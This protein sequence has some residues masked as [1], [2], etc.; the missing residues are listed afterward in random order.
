VGVENCRYT[1]FLKRLIETPWSQSPK[2]QGQQVKLFLSVLQAVDL[3]PGVAFGALKV[4]LLDQCHNL[5]VVVARVLGYSLLDLIP[6][7]TQKELVQLVELGGDALEQRKNAGVQVHLQTLAVCLSIALK[8]MDS[9]RDGINVLP[10]FSPIVLKSM[11]ACLEPQEPVSGGCLL[12][13][14]VSAEGQDENSALNGHALWQGTARQLFLLGSAYPLQAMLEQTAQDFEKFKCCFDDHIADDIIDSWASNCTTDALVFVGML[15]K[16]TLKTDDAQ[17]CSIKELPFRLVLAV[18]KGPKRLQLQQWLSSSAG[19]DSETTWLEGILPMLCS[20]S[21]LPEWK[22][23]VEFDKLTVLAFVT[24]LHLSC[25]ACKMPSE[26]TQDLLRALPHCSSMLLAW[27]SSA[28]DIETA[29]RA[30]IKG[31]KDGMC[32]YSGLQQLLSSVLASHESLLEEAEVEVGLH[33]IDR[34]LNHASTAGVCRSQLKLAISGVVGLLKSEFRTARIF[35]VKF[36]CNVLTLSKHEQSLLEFS[37]D[38]SPSSDPRAEDGHGQHALFALDI[39]Q[40]SNATHQLHTE[41]SDFSNAKSSLQMLRDRIGQQ[42]VSCEGA[43]AYGEMAEQLGLQPPTSSDYPASAM[44]LTCTTKENLQKIIEGTS[45]PVPQLLEGATGVG[46]SAV[47]DEAA[48]QTGNKLVRFNMSSTISIDDLLGKVTLEFKDGREQFG[49]IEQP[50]TV[51]FKNGFWLLLDELNLAQDMVLQA[52]EQAID[53]KQLILNDVSNAE[54]FGAEPI[55]MHR[56]FRLF[57]TQNPNSGHFKGKREPLSESFLTRLSPLVFKELPQEEWVEIVLHKL[58]AAKLDP[59]H[60]YLGELATRLVNFHCKVLELLTNKRDPSNRDTF[61][62]SDKGPHSAIS[63]RELLKM[64]HQLAWYSTD[65]RTWPTTE[66]R[67]D[68]CAFESWCTYGA[69]FRSMAARALILAKILEIWHS[70]GSILGDMNFRLTPQQLEIS[71]VCMDRHVYDVPH[72]MDIDSSFHQTWITIAIEAHRN[73][74]AVILSALSIVQHGMYWVSDHWLRDWI[75]RAQENE[76]VCDLL[77]FAAFGVALYSA[78]IRSQQL[79]DQICEVFAQAASVSVLQINQSIKANCQHESWTQGT[80]VSPTPPFVVTSRVKT[81]WKEILRALR[82]QS[83]VLLQGQSGCGKSGTINALAHILGQPVSA[84]C[85]TSETEP[86]ALVG[87]MG[88]ASPESLERVA[89]QDGVVTETYLAGSWV[90]LDNISDADPCVLERL[91]PLLEQPAVWILSEAGRTEEEDLK[92]GFRV[93]ATMT[94]PSSSQPGSQDLSPAMAN[95]FTMILLSNVGETSSQESSEEIAEAG[96][97]HE[98]TDLATALLGV[99]AEEARLAARFCYSVWVSCESMKFAMTSRLTFRNLVRLLDCAYLLQQDHMSSESPLKLHC[100]LL[101]AFKVAISGQF[102]T[103]ESHRQVEAELTARLGSLFPQAGQLE[104]VDYEKYLVGSTDHVLTASRKAHAKSVAACV[105]CNL[106][107]LLEGPAAVGKTALILALGAQWPAESGGSRKLERVNNTDTTTIQD[108][109]GSHIPVGKQFLFQKGALVNA[110]EKGC[111]FLADEFNLAD[112]AVM[113]ALFPLLEGK[114]EIDVPGLGV[115]SAHAG[116]R[117]FATQNDASYA[118]RHKLPLAL[119]NRFVEVQIEDFPEAELPIIIQHRKDRDERSDWPENIAEIECTRLASVYTKLRSCSEDRITLREIIKWVKRQAAFGDRCSW[120]FAGYT[121]LTSKLLSQGDKA[122]ADRLLRMDTLFDDVF[123]TKFVGSM[124]VEIKQLQSRFS[125]TMEFVE[126]GAGSLISV[127]VDGELTNSP[128]FVADTAPP[129]RFLQALTR[130]IQ[131]TKLHEPVLL[132]GPT[133]YKTLLVDT[134]QQITNT[135]ALRR[136]YLTPDT[137]TPELIGQIHPYTVVGALRDVEKTARDVLVRVQALKLFSSGAEQHKTSLKEIKTITSRVEEHLGIFADAIEQY[138]TAHLKIG[139]QSRE[140]KPDRD[141]DHNF[142]VLDD[143]DDFDV[144]S[145]SGDLEKLVD[146]AGGN[147]DKLVANLDKL[148]ENSTAAADDMVNG[149]ASFE[150]MH[151][152]AQFDG[153]VTPRGCDSSDDDWDRDDD[154]DIFINSEGSWP[155]FDDAD[156]AG[157]DEVNSGFGV[158][159]QDDGFGS[160]SP[161]SLFEGSTG[162]EIESQSILPDDGFTEFTE[163]TQ[164]A[165]VLFVSNIAPETTLREFYEHFQK[166]GDIDDTKFLEGCVATELI[167]KDIKS[168]TSAEAG[169]H[170]VCDVELV[171]SR[172]NGGDGFGN[173]ASPSVMEFGLGDGPVQNSVMFEDSGITAASQILSQIE[174]LI[175]V[176]TPPEKPDSALEMMLNR[177]RVV[178]E[179]SVKPRVSGGEAAANGNPIFLFRDGPVTEA[180]KLGRAVLLEDFNLPSQAVTERLNSLLEPSP[181]FSVTE[182]ITIAHSADKE[183]DNIQNVQ[184]PLTFQVFATAHR[185]TSSQRLNISPATRS[186]FT[187]IDCSSYEDCDEDLRF[188]LWFRFNQKLR[189]DEKEHASKLAD[190]IMALKKLVDVRWSDLNFHSKTGVKIRQWL[191]MVD[192]VCEHSS[193]VPVNDRL[194]LA[195]RFFVFD[196]ASHE[197]GMLTVV[198]EWIISFIEGG[199]DAGQYVRQLFELDGLIEKDKPFSVTLSG[200]ITS[201]YTGVMVGDSNHLSQGENKEKFERHKE[202]LRG[203]LVPEAELQRRAEVEVLNE[204][205]HLARTPTLVKNVARV[206]A[207]IVAKSSLLLEGPPGVGKTAVVEQVAKL[208]GV[209]CERINFSANTTTDQLIGN[210]IPRCVA[211]QRIFE[212]Q[213]GVLLRAIKDK[214]WLLFDELNLA[215][216]DVL[217]R[218]ASLLNPDVTQFL[219]PEKGTADEIDKDGICIFAT[220]N[221]VSTGGGRNRLP[222]SIANFFTIVQLD[223]YAAGKDDSP[224]ELD[225]IMQK[226][227]HRLIKPDGDDW[228]ILTEDLRA[229][230]YATHKAICEKVAAREIGAE[231]GPFEFNLRDLTKLRDVLGGNAKDLRDYYRF[232]T[233]PQSKTDEQSSDQD[234]SDTDVRLLALRKFVDLVYCRCFQSVADQ[235]AARDLIN[236]KLACKSDRCASDSGVDSSVNGFVRIGSAHLQTGDSGDFDQANAKPLVHSRGTVERLEVLAAASQSM[237]PV[238]LEGDTCSGKSALVRELARLARRHLVV[239]SM[240]H[241]TE[242]GDLIGQWLPIAPEAVEGQLTSTI[243]KFLETTAKHL[244]L[245]VLPSVASDTSRKMVISGLV[246][247]MG[248]AATSTSL[249]EQWKQAEATEILRRCLDEQHSA[250]MLPEVKSRTRWLHREAEQ[251]HTKMGEDQQESSG[252]MSFTFVE[253]DFVRAIRNGDWVLLDNINSAPPEVIERLNS[254]TESDPVLNLY[255]CAEGAKLD[256]LHGIHP[257]WRLFATSNTHRVGSSKL[258]GAMLNRMLRIWLP[259][260]DATLPAVKNVEEHDLFDVVSGMFDGVHGGKELATLTLQFHKVAVDMARNTLEIAPMTGFPFTF[261]TIQHSVSMAVTLM[262]GARMKPVN[263]VVLSMVRCYVACLPETEHQE[264]MIQRLESLVGANWLRDSSFG[265][266]IQSSREGGARW[267]RDSEPVKAAMLQVQEC[268]A[269]TVVLSVKCMLDGGHVEEASH[270][271]LHLVDAVLSKVMPD[272][273]FVV[274]LRSAAGNKVQLQHVISDAPFGGLLPWQ[275][276]AGLEHA[277]QR[278]VQAVLNFVEWATFSDFADRAIVLERVN[279]AAA[280]LKNVLVELRSTGASAGLLQ[281]RSVLE[282]AE[283][284]LRHIDELSKIQTWFVLLNPGNAGSSMLSFKDSHQQFQSALMHCKERA[285]A[286]AVEMHLASPVKNSHRTLATIFDQLLRKGVQAAALQRFSSVVLWTG[287]AWTTSF[288]LPQELLFSQSNAK[289]ASEYFGVEKLRLFET[290]YCRIALGNFLRQ[291]IRTDLTPQLTEFCEALRNCIS[292][293]DIGILREQIR[294]ETSLLAKQVASAAQVEADRD[295][296]SNRIR[297]TEALIGSAEQDEDAEDQQEGHGEKAQGA[298][299]NAGARMAR[300]PSAEA[301]IEH[302]AEVASRKSAKAAV[303]S[304]DIIAAQASLCK[305]KAELDSRLRQVSEA[306][307]SRFSLLLA[308]AKQAVA[309]EVGKQYWK[310]LT[311]LEVTSAMADVRDVL[312]HIS[313]Q[314]I[315]TVRNAGKYNPAFHSEFAASFSRI[316]CEEL[317]HP[318]LLLA[319]AFLGLS[320]HFSLPDDASFSFVQHG[321]DNPVLQGNCRFEVI[322][323]FHGHPQCPLMLFVVDTASSVTHVFEQQTKSSF[324]ASYASKFAM[325]RQHNHE[326]PEWDCLRKPA[327]DLEQALMRV[328]CALARFPFESPPSTEQC[329]EHQ[330]HL[331]PHVM[332]GRELLHEICEA[333]DELYACFG[334]VPSVGT[335]TSITT[336]MGFML[337]LQALVEHNCQSD[338]DQ[339]DDREFSEEVDMFSKRTAEILTAMGGLYDETVF[340]IERVHELDHGLAECMENLTDLERAKVASTVDQ[341]ADQQLYECSISAIK[342]A[343]EGSSLL[344]RCMLERRQAAIQLFI[345]LQH[346]VYFAASVALRNASANG[347]PLP[348]T[349]QSIAFFDH[350]INELCA[351]VRINACDVVIKRPG[352]FSADYFQHLHDSVVDEFEAL[353]CSFQELEKHGYG[354]MFCNLDGLL[355]SADLHE[356]PDGTHANVTKKDAPEVRSTAQTHLKEMKAALKDRLLAARKLSPPPRNIMREMRDLLAQMQGIEEDANSDPTDMQLLAFKRQIHTKRGQLEEYER[357]LDKKHPLRSR[358]KHL[359]TDFDPSHI[360]LS[361]LKSGSDNAP[362][363]RAC[364]EVIAL[365][366]QLEVETNLPQEHLSG[367]SSDASLKHLV[368]ESF[369]SQCWFEATQICVDPNPTAASLERFKVLSGVLSDELAIEFTKLSKSDLEASHIA[370]T[371]LKCDSTSACILLELIRARQQHF[372]GASAATGP[373]PLCLNYEVVQQACRPVW[374]EATRDQLVNILNCYEVLD[375]LHQRRIDVENVVSSYDKGVTV[376]IGPTEFRWSDVLCL[377]T[378]E[379][380]ACVQR[381]VRIEALANGLLRHGITKEQRDQTDFLEDL[382]AGGLSKDV[383]SVLENIGAHP[384]GRD[385]IVNP[386]SLLG[387]ILPQEVYERLMQ[388]TGVHLLLSG[389]AALVHCCKDSRNENVLQRTQDCLPLQLKYA[390]MLMCGTLQYL[391]ELENPHHGIWASTGNI[392]LLES[393]L[394]KLPGAQE[395]TRTQATLTEMEQL[396]AVYTERKES[397]RTRDIELQQS[398]CNDGDALGCYGRQ[399][400][401]LELAELERGSKLLQVSIETIQASIKQTERTLQDHRSRLDGEVRSET[402][403]VV[404]SVISQLNSMRSTYFSMLLC[405]ITE[406]ELAS[407]TADVA[408]IKSD[409]GSCFG[410]VAM[411]IDGL[412]SHDRSRRLSESDISKARA[413]CEDAREARKAMQATLQCSLR[414]DDTFRLTAIWLGDLLINGIVGTRRALCLQARYS[415]VLNEH[416]EG[417]RAVQ[418]KLHLCIHD[419]DGLV[420]QLGTL[421]DETI[422]KRYS[423]VNAVCSAAVAV[424][425][426]CVSDIQ[427]QFGAGGLGERV[428]QRG[429]LRAIDGLVAYGL[430]AAHAACKYVA[431]RQLQEA[432]FEQQVFGTT[433]KHPATA[434]FAGVVA[435]R[436]WEEILVQLKLQMQSILGCEKYLLPQAVLDVSTSPFR[437][438]Q[439]LEEALLSMG[440]PVHAAYAMRAF[441]SNCT[442]GGGGGILNK[443]REPLRKSRCGYGAP[444]DLHVTCPFTAEEISALKGA[445]TACLQMKSI[446]ASCFLTVSAG[447]REQ[448]MHSKLCGDSGGAVA[449]LHENMG[450]LCAVL[451]ERYQEHNHSSSCERTMAA[452]RALLLELLKLSVRLISGDF[453]SNVKVLEIDH[454]LD[455]RILRRKQSQGEVAVELVHRDAEGKPTG[456]NLEFITL[457]DMF[458]VAKVMGKIEAQAA[459]AEQGGCSKMLTSDQAAK[460]FEHAE[461]QATVIRHGLQ[462]AGVLL[463]HLYEIAPH[464]PSL[465]HLPLEYEAMCNKGANLLSLSLKQLADGNSAD[466]LFEDLYGVEE[467][468]VLKHMIEAFWDQARQL[469]LPTLKGSAI[470]GQINQLTKACDD[471]QHHLTAAVGAKRRVRGEQRNKWF[472]RLEV[473]WE[474]WNTAE[475]GKEAEHNRKLADFSAG[476]ARCE[477][478]AKQIIANIRLWSFATKKDASRHLDFLQQQFWQHTVPYP[479]HINDFERGGLTGIWVG[480]GYGES[481]YFDFFAFFAHVEVTVT[482]HNQPAVGRDSGMPKIPT[483]HTPGAPPACLY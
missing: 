401:E 322:V 312:K 178:W 130:L 88:P 123:H 241:E 431:V 180:A 281:S 396:L 251:L 444:D 114:R 334:L 6:G 479:G 136:F 271:A 230:V 368:E 475:R 214:K 189:L 372:V 102:K 272:S 21:Q 303:L 458:N 314:L 463:Q 423:D 212:W 90:M 198:E 355:K 8:S 183:V 286:F 229:S 269:S 325:H 335:S 377:L 468:M 205:V 255:E 227:Y 408:K 48:K 362:T 1:N 139:Q 36:I 7:L 263:A 433:D 482:S 319:P 113:S 204:K 246:A 93:L 371:F 83:P 193:E 440:D 380:L 52:I 388:D 446:T 78:Q 384:T 39:E 400:V 86:A 22:E 106:P 95:R 118:N 17:V 151:N 192:F 190:A 23:H 280:T 199:K 94:P 184:L 306:N 220:M 369:R 162:I 332:S 210:V 356:D 5:P 283:A 317:Y 298:P 254:I 452:T 97:I 375:H 116:F 470:T 14:V 382:Y 224:D 176:V 84:V 302:N 270:I 318:L 179:G 194:C 428:V 211:G 282:S 226:L 37:F 376:C 156:D 245:L 461:L 249:L 450:L 121:L 79:R 447:H 99:S 148:V 265:V 439:D 28:I 61:P 105:V 29:V 476:K 142:S 449:S 133:S 50:F 201:K 268:V 397:A 67:H 159:D 165:P 132:I 82:I 473:E 92:E 80:A 185:S 333:R 469:T 367:A 454:S 414:D 208:L 248:A 66:S 277:A 68:I 164:T 171:V 365:C 472:Q 128:L 343:I 112:P 231:G 239:I 228:A 261:R 294:T 275:I 63:I 389:H 442:N 480:L 419:K 427:N 291:F 18:A 44:V 181:S 357:E 221:P 166:F 127:V 411:T 91:N 258:S 438:Q 413:A 462:E 110:L 115:V 163:T 135:V 117:F 247:V 140:A 89:W 276:E 108:Y 278:T 145:T 434:R 177:I 288:K 425:K 416:S 149:A 445:V 143:L 386:R 379:L 264:I 191:K 426:I 188:V 274:S 478:E 58:I 41:L 146:H 87:Q 43:G 353:G 237:M 471:Y 35:G 455:Q 126:K 40:T 437:V 55:H 466:S 71:G 157:F 16:S 215:P 24:T 406:H 260:L 53:T 27:G 160:A 392:K 358:L 394:S 415:T 330:W 374:E 234:L 4:M 267:E 218:L 77:C 393:V 74:R 390:G 324:G 364:D 51:A 395:Q 259:G 326:M 363:N 60:S 161:T 456:A 398:L 104:P 65:G 153:A 187:E 31:C 232:S 273:H 235:E 152:S 256:R 225:I 252:S 42:S 30:I 34:C 354:A 448:S 342:K 418:Q 430:Q 474:K 385:S 240:T 11:L 336:L 407:A 202:L 345:T 209:K 3:Q 307:V 54:N 328:M 435:A 285:A 155:A 399:G 101:E 467:G 370:A 19:Q 168:S 154:G 429:V 172:E 309:K 257:S 25:V 443:W 85:L 129:P 100:A 305:A 402:M 481:T 421:F 49:F 451:Q 238:L 457:G 233:A 344:D 346:V 122:A 290:K 107:V 59:D 299:E 292:G 313:A 465:T 137:E 203:K 138:E 279:G 483:T 378:P 300:Q 12:D 195:A 57:A 351:A 72:V 464:I 141:A 243:S 304:R 422:D 352:G 96:F 120:A 244:L 405:C 26:V 349:L 69:R 236:D 144:G 213:D 338:T 284:C 311:Q 409:F 366:D 216:P 119:R 361:F 341:L 56:D 186:R 360:Q 391:G 410:F 477:A 111:W 387:K 13:A 206:F 75:S 76:Q 223:G 296:A 301:D 287:L 293:L 81:A 207:T 329:H 73:A 173:G 339:F 436:D 200:A 134:W 383:L 381:A 331:G 441:S 33:A 417:I 404:T 323:V 10:L 222:R 9:G 337:N 359:Q 158:P 197:G 15:F 373:H 424:T 175:A 262:Q 167:F 321:V 308:D 219:V 432:K 170:F 125:A 47:I 350:K 131:A 103:E 320:E 266:H 147:F 460:W 310:S 45:N 453:E 348:R 250:S 242:V 182:D 297:Q 217:D 98:M 64:V 32:E 38:C 196:A 253:S 420:V 327:S 150:A 174:R 412:F 459:A 2:E 124:Q 340:Q 295:E 46:K 109:L 169:S 20:H 315:R 70:D 347:T 289:S 62:D 316:P 403:K